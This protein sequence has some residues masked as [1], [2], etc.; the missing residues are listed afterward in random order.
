MNKVF[1]S[2]KIARATCGEK[3]CSHSYRIHEAL[4]RAG[5]SSI[6][7]ARKLG[8]SPQAVSNVLLGKSHSARILDAMRKLGVPEEFLFDPRKNTSIEKENIAEG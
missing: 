8:V 5:I 3:R 1:Q 6:G 4:A 2:S 7:L